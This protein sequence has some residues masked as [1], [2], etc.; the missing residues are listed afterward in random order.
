MLILIVSACTKTNNIFLY[1]LS[2]R[3]YFGIWL[4]SYYRF[5]NNIETSST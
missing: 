1:L 3:I 5:W 4:S 2:F